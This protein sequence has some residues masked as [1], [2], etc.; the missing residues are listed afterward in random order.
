MEKLVWVTGG[1]SGIGNAISRLFIEKGKTV[2][3]TAR[4]LDK[5]EKLRQEFENEHV[6]IEQCDIRDYKS[7]K[8]IYN[9]YKSSYIFDTLI[10]NAGVTSFKP[11]K[12]NDIEEID[13]IVKTNLLGAI[14]ATQIVLPD[15]ISNNKGKI[16]NVLSVA[17]IKTF[18]N[19]SI[20]AASKAGL[21]A[22][23]NVLREEIRKYNISVTNILPGATATP[24]WSEDNLAKFSERMMN[25]EDVAELIYN[26]YINE[27][28]V[29]PEEITIRPI[30]GDL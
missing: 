26:L 15:F 11:F 14:Y 7:L 16:I 28:T 24:I 12:Y 25:P 19:S 10:N 29:I 5:L 23:S 18:T 27:S 21:L 2:L 8:T 9:S 4:S 3:V 6:F 22:F 13:S 1:S 30:L 20:Y 17:A